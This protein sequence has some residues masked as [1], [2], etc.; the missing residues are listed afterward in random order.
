MTHKVTYLLSWKS[1]LTICEV[2]TLADAKYLRDVFTDAEDVPKI[3]VKDT[4]ICELK[5]D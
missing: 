2:A 4:T 5:E 1:G 3:M